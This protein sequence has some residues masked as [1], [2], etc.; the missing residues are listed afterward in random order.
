MPCR[1]CGS[2][3][4]RTFLDLGEQPLANAY[5]DTQDQPEQRYPLHA[6]IC[7]SCLLVQADA[8]VSP[9][10]IFND[11]AFFSSYSK[12]WVEHTRQ[13]AKAMTERFE[14]DAGS[15][16]VEVASNDG[17]LLSQFD[18]P[19]VLGVEP[20]E[21]VARVARLNGVP[22]I[23]EFFTG[24]LAL[25]PADLMVA[26][27]V[28]GHVPDLNG[29]VDGFRKTLK[30]EGVLTI[31][32][33]W[34]LHLIER[35]EFDTI[36][37]EHF[38]YFSF[39]ALEQVLARH[40]L[41]VFD[42]EMLDVHGGS[43]RAFVCHIDSQQAELATTHE[44]RV[45]EER[46]GLWSADS[47]AYIDFA[48]RVLDRLSDLHAFLSQAES[49]VGAGAPAKGNTLLNALGADRDT[50]RFVTDT[51][52]HKQ[53]RW[54][55]GSRIPIVEPARIVEVCPEFVLVLAW[56]WLDEVMASLPQV[57]EWGGRFVVPNPV[58][59]V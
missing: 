57:S 28:F 37:H 39:E 25:P 44:I 8:V 3:L 2:E 55:P 12:S 1:V 15:F 14:L 20:A 42:V 24:D 29:F 48:I 22:T 9:S 59:I 18:G 7:D 34:L 17:C 33:P 45:I 11:Y 38:S 32:V 56:N 52:P 4:T 19:V 16:V 27:N 43:L 49:V 47:E 54:L 41:R 13:Y 46:A 36:Y 26:N 35:C 53:G 30:P 21:N 31:E 6:R 50:L 10:G 40:Q 58:R 5:L 23:T 51:S